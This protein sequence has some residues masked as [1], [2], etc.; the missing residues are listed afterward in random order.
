MIDRVSGSLL[1]RSG[2]ALSGVL[3]LACVLHAS[4][5]TAWSQTETATASDAVAIEP[6]VARSVWETARQGHEDGLIDLLGSFDAQALPDWFEASVEQ[7]K[8][9]I[10]KR[11]ADRDTQ[12]ADA[13]TAL[14][15]LITSAQASGSAKDLNEALAKAVELQL[16]RADSTGLLREERIQGLMATAEATARKAEDEGDWLTASELFFRL[17]VLTDQRVQFRADVDRLNRR[18]GMIR[19]YVPERLWELR[20]ARRIADGE[21]P[22][23]AY[24]SYGDNYREKLTTV[25]P[26]MVYLA[27]HR[28]SL[29]HVL[30]DDTERSGVSMRSML[31]GGL[32]A[33]ETMATTLDLYRAFEG[34]RDEG[35]R[36]EFIAQVRAARQELADAQT[37]DTRDMRAVV[38]KVM[39]AN[40]QT[41]RILP[42]AVLHEFGNGAMAKTDDYTAII[43]PDELARFRRSTQGEFT[44]VGIQIE[45][46]ELQ[47]IRVVT[48]LEGTPAQRAGVQ[49]GDVLKRIN[50]ISAVG[51]GLDQ[52]VEVI[53]GPAETSVELT[54]EREREDGEKE[55]VTFH[56]T[57]R[58]I[59]LPSI[60]GWEKTGPGDMD[61]SWFIDADAGIGYIRLT[62]FTEDTT[63]DFDTAV[64][65]MRASGLNGLILDLRYN[66]GGLLDQAVSIANRFYEDGLIV[67]TESASGTVTDQQ[68]AKP[69]SPNK[70]VAD[71][72]VVVLI[73]EGSASASEI[74]S[75][76]VQAAADHGKARAVVIGQRSFGKGSVQNVFSLSGGTAAM[77]VTT[78]Y[79]KIDAPRLIHRNPE[80]TEWGIEP[81]L[82]VRMLPS[83]EEAALMLR[84]QSDVLALDPAGNVIVTEDRPD[85]D[86]LIADGIDLQVHTALIV[87]QSQVGEPVV[88]SAQRDGA[89]PATTVSP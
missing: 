57:R 17:H 71:I 59:D 37:V 74:V 6:S 43:W 31:L 36:A 34:L 88:R 15:E 26:Q 45:L 33:I 23:P 25:Q 87:L 70:S 3:G 55:E 76:A 9:N 21:S 18:L 64:A 78:Q 63:R 42:E 56:L 81:D 83:Q 79:Y 41:V 49:T 89:V 28:A 35:R 20:N 46:D 62:G 80:S 32:D 85:P 86:S 2:F 8:A 14:N 67:R 4:A 84:R 65:S 22:L 40:E 13:D 54:V 48:P 47:N 52:A 68:F 50:G 29:N 19:L 30:R 16:L 73:N 38:Q 12:T 39:Q 75:G 27:I 69:I 77:K 53:T 11:E 7:F 51:L 72:P 1:R 58:A 82:A 24:N 44:G 10:A 5:G 60:K 61:W 66:P